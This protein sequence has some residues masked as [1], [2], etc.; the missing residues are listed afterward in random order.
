MITPPIPSFLNSFWEDA[1]SLK[2]HLQGFL[3]L[4]EQ[5]LE[6][7]LAAG[8]K[9]MAELGHKD[10]DWEKATALYQY[11]VKNEYLFE[12][13]AWHLNS[14]DYIG[15]TLLVIAKYAQGRVL[16]FG[17]GI[18]TH[19]IGAALSPN[20]KEV[21][22][23]DINPIN[24]EFVE[25]RAKQLGLDKKIVLCQEMPSSE[26]F[27]TIVC[28]D[29]LEHL[30]DPIQ[31]LLTFHQSLDDAGK[32][33]MNWYFFKGFN[34]EYPFHHDE[35]ELLDR[36]FQTLQTKFVEVFHPYLIT[37]RCYRKWI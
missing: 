30:P 12:L 17:G 35:P 10:F 6:S 24:C 7:K 14:H 23:F 25:Y 29:V 37:A 3:S 8:Q 22:Y 20:V 36:F 19:A 33:I 13:G 16:D 1:F 32:I 21:F 34:Q 4:D 28:F 18:G 9:E 26:M 5:T 11:Q 31:Q 27:D 2:Q 15:N